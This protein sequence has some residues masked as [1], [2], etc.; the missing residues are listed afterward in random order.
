M[1][2]LTNLEEL[3]EILL[4]QKDNILRSSEA[5]ITLSFNCDGISD[6]HHIY[7]DSLGDIYLPDNL[8]ESFETYG[9]DIDISLESA[10]GDMVSKIIAVF[11][12]ALEIE[13]DRD[14][15]FFTDGFEEN[16]IE[17]IYSSAEW[18][19]NNGFI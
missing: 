13:I 18:Y 7:I 2:N 12:D 1:S 15:I 11:S 10:D 3:E 6:N 16:D 14:H 17:D 4:S 9:S 5:D 8:E 19:I